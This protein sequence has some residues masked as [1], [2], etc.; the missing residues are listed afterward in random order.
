MSDSLQSHGLSP[1]DFSV[2]GMSQQEYWSGLPFLP[3]GDLPNPGLKPM[4]PVVPALAG[5]FFTTE[6]PG[7]CKNHNSDKCRSHAWIL[8]NLG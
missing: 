3:P 4:S 8:A 6:P 1:A 2:H 5:T 7:K